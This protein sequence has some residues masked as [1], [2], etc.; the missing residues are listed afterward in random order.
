MEGNGGEAE[1]SEKNLGVLEKF[2]NLDA[3]RDA[4][5]NEH[6]D[7]WRDDEPD[8]EGPAP[9]PEGDDEESK[10]GE[11]LVG[12]PEERP[13]NQAAFA[14]GVESPVR[15]RGRKGGEGASKN[16]GKDGGSV[17]IG[18]NGERMAGRRR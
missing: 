3:H 13:E 16:N 14:G 8:G 9:E 17:L 18:K 5:K 12:G 11:E 10:S 1:D 6:Q 7:S 15:T 2:A 4:R